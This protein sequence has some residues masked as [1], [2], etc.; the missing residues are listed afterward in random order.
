MNDPKAEALEAHLSRVPRGGGALDGAPRRERAARLAALGAWSWAIE[1]AGYPA[2][3]RELAD[4]PAVVFGR[5]VTLPPL[6][7]AIAVVGARAATPYGR[8]HA[9]R[10]SHDLARLGFT[11]VSGLARGIDRAAHEGALAAGG[12]TVA[13]L[14]SG[15][16]H[17]VPR[18]H[19]ELAERVIERG[20]LVSEYGAG[21]PP[22]KGAFVVRNRLIAALAAA[23]V[24]VEASLTSGALRTAQVAATLGRARL[25]VPGDLDREVA[26]GPHALLRT[27]ALV[28]ESAA[29]VLA[30]I[31]RADA[32]RDPT[33]SRERPR[34]RVAAAEARPAVPAGAP[35]IARVRAAL[36]STP[37][38]VEGIAA[39][40]A[41]PLDET[42]AALL[43]LEWAG[44]A[45]RL[46]GGT[47]RRGGEDGIA[48]SEAR[49]K[50]AR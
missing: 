17:V 20:T 4:P 37:A 11:I 29:D 9:E 34:E 39:G 30:A 50:G 43:E 44:L 18:D 1:D 28:C 38:W 35:T 36:T 26:R 48:R 46:A 47:W 27:G 23:V 5:G 24:V 40:A 49:S 3:L 45:E 7:R 12:A 15:L 32:G 22:F 21:P 19:R 13:V 14:P 33:P 41:A 6:D 16:D 25:A 10:L 8:R 2:G 42:F 31:D